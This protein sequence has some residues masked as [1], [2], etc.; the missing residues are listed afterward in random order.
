MRYDSTENQFSPHKVE[1]KIW[2][3]VRNHQESSNT[4][5]QLWSLSSASLSMATVPQPGREVSGGRVCKELQNHLWWETV[6]KEQLFSISS[7]TPDE[8]NR[9]Q[10]GKRQYE[11]TLCG[12]QQTWRLF[13]EGY[14]SA[15]LP[16]EMGAVRRREITESY[17]R[18]EGTSCIIWSSSPTFLG[19]SM[20]Y[21]R[22]PSQ[23][24]SVQCWGIQH[25]PQE[26]IV[27][28][29]KSFLLCPTEIS[30][31]VTCSYHPLSFPCDS[32]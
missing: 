21:T 1:K 14:R 29:V 9:S 17:T 18:L 32:I 10:V 26:M 27:L 6:V 28:V 5:A 16:E 22:Q 2:W 7:S 20:V 3:N 15:L 23:I 30:P 11:V 19:K 4:W 24:L 8:G 31:G 25:F 13:T 12:R